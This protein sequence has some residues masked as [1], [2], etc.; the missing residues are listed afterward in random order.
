MNRIDQ[1]QRKINTDYDKLYFDLNEI[2]QF[3]MEDREQQ[4]QRIDD[5][6]AN[7]TECR[8][9]IIKLGGKI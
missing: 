2:I 6:E 3:L 1:R 8:L 7:V 4:L 5:L 9:A